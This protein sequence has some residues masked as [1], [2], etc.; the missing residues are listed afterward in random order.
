MFCRNCGIPLAG[1]AV[2]CP[3]CG[4]TVTPLSSARPPVQNVQPPYPNPYGHN[5]FGRQ[6]PEDRSGVGFNLLSF[7]FPVIGL[8]LFLVWKDQKP[9]CARSIAKWA[10]IGF[11]AETILIIVVVVLSIAL[12]TVAA[13]SFD[14]GLYGDFAYGM[15]MRLPGRLH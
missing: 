1:D 5:A 3:K 6:Q 10:L 4:V 13:P 11:I 12:F 2:A 7:L 8:I 9:H 14:Y 15:A